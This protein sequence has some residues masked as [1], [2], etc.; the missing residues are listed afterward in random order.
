MIR[1]VLLATALFVFSTP[2]AFAKKSFD[3]YWTDVGLT[4]SDII[5]TNA[6]CNASEKAFIACF[7]AINSGLAVEKTRQTAVPSDRLK[8]ETGFGAALQ[9][10]GPVSIV[11]P[12]KVESEDLAEMLDIVRKER[13]LSHD[14]R[15]ALYKAKA[16]T[17]VDFEALYTHV[18]SGAEAKRLESVTVGAMHNALIG[19]LHDP[20]TYVVPEQMMMDESTAGTRDFAGIGAKMTSLKKNGK[21]QAIVQQPF[22]SGPGYKAGI[23][24]KDVITHVD[25]K[26][27][28]EMEL[29][30]VVEKIK[31]PIGTVVKLT[32]QRGTDTL[33]FSVTRGLIEMKNVETK[34]VGDASDVAY[35]KLSDFM[36][37]DK[38]GKTLVYKESK[39]AVEKMLA[40]SPKGLIFDLRDNGGGLLTESVRISSLFL[41]T[42][43]LVVDTKDL[44]TMKSRPSSTVDKPLTDLPLIVLINSR[45][46]SASEIVAGA[47]QDHQRAF[48]FGERTFGKGTVQRIG[49]L[50]P[51]TRKAAFGVLAYNDKLLFAETI[52]RFYQPSGRTNQIAGISPDVEVFSSPTPTAA[53]KAALR[54]EDEYAALSPIGTKWVQPRPTE[55]AKLQKCITDKGVANTAFA[56]QEK[57][58]LGPDYQLLVAIDGI[59]CIASEKIWTADMPAPAFAAPKAPTLWEQIFSN[60]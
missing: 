23:R 45:S 32:V 52:Q 29:T 35:I 34:Q 18:Q 15:V 60:E 37:R 42:G 8:K 13:K 51:F 19:A 49:G 3:Q 38:D 40:S 33:E 44:K 57:A 12:K 30:E 36:T 24:A 11:T 59:Q 41:K 1:R 9:E 39:A 46:A 58:G 26:D 14:A 27:V 2:S 7:D 50:N 53:D 20:H 54:E 56:T 10:F 55:V 25:G 21:T 43:S 28:T 22:E 6:E 4:F 16:T 5:V 31:G 48:L 47:L 17:P